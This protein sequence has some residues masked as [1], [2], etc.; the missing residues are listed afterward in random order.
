MHAQAAM[1]PSRH[2]FAPS[3]R[4]FSAL[5]QA[6][7]QL[8]QGTSQGRKH[9]VG[10][11]PSSPSPTLLGCCEVALSQCLEQ[12]IRQSRHLTWKCT[13]PLVLEH[14][15]ATKSSDSQSVLRA[16]AHMRHVGLVTSLTKWQK[17]GHKLGIDHAVTQQQFCQKTVPF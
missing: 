14:D 17:H 7:T 3:P 9:G 2:A 10:G 4:A 6:S 1:R 8:G 16:C 12:N 11:A 13:Q 15:L 5:T